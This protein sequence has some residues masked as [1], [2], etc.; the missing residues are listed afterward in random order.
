MTI[1][2][3]APPTGPT[4]S[5]FAA[6]LDQARRAP[7]AEAL[8]SR[9][10]GQWRAWSW[11]RLAAQTEL[12]ARG[13][14]ALGVRPGDRIVA[15]G[16]LGAD[17]IVTLFA[18]DAL[19]A[20]VVLADDAP[21]AQVVGEAPFAFADGTHELERLLRLRGTAL[22]AAVVGDA[23]VVPTSRQIDG[24]PLH[25]IAQLLDLGRSHT[26]LPSHA[27]PD[28]L[29]KV[30]GQHGVLRAL[31]TSEAAVPELSRADR[32]FADFPPTWATGLVFVLHT[33]PAR[34]PLLLIPEPHGDAA[35]DQ[36]EA[37]ANF[38]LAS[39]ERLAA[40]V[41]MLRARVPARGIGARIAR[42]VL[43]GRRPLLGALA[44]S[45]MRA[46]M[47]WAATRFTISDA[48]LAEPIERLLRTLGIVPA[49]P[50]SPTSVV[51][52]PSAGASSPSATVARTL[53]ATP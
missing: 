32:V 36:R 12:A 31:G 10:R 41:A 17:L 6:L 42:A 50:A 13:W 34:A 4:A 21:Q 26:A 5:P 24:V 28:A 35:A 11:Q 37:C 30:A 22:R 16:P 45:R 53:A 19:G 51:R 20:S 48:A 25:S 8:R 39:P 49:A 33:W 27:V 2:I 52:H 46:G 14:A 9:R 15:L 23:A 40:A 1:S 7:R 43:D 47:G 38:W 3:V 44:R 18:A 29:V